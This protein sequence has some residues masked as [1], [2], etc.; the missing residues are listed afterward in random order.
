MVSSLKIQQSA[1]NYSN[2]KTNSVEF[3][4]NYSNWKTKS[5]ESARNYSNWKTKKIQGEI[6]S[7]AL[8]KPLYQ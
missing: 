7:Q 1:R 8:N 2:W 5:V 3:A 4:R 6:E